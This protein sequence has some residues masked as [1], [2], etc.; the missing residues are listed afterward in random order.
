VA[1]NLADDTV[2][3]VAAY[4]DHMLGRGTPFAITDRTD[5]DTKTSIGQL[6]QDQAAHH[7]MRVSMNHKFMDSLSGSI[8]YV[9][10]TGTGLAGDA[11]AIAPV[12][13]DAL[14]RDL[15]AY[16]HREHY[17]SVSSRIDT[18]IPRTGTQITTILR[19]YPGIS[20][21][22]IDLFYDPK[23]TLTKGVH[24]FVK[25]AIPL[26]EFLGT[27]GRWE[28]LVDLRN[29]F[30]QGRGVIRAGEREISVTR[31]PRSVRFGLNL[32]LY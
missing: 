31:N 27:P 32:N 4:E 9:Y 23:D 26:P 19:W 18:R 24:V 2:V 15:V 6:R 25:Q 11:G 22:P 10:G 8:A 20:L 5:Q 21:S 14:A 28:A 13:P 30:D 29:V 16:L 12:A 7:G 17:H 3:E 1:H